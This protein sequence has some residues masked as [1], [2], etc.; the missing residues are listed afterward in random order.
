MAL[1]VVVEDNY[2]FVIGSGSV[3][4]DLASNPF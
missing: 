1:I 4:F 3:F 2:F